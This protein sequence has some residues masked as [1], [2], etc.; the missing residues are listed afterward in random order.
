VTEGEALPEAHMANS[1]SKGTPFLYL[2]PVQ[3]TPQKASLK[4]K[5]K[6]SNVC[7][8]YYFLLTVFGITSVAVT[9]HSIPS[10][11]RSTEHSS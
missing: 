2:I 7:F 3:L 6:N 10:A 1:P 4:I 8:I 5:N 9:C 11:V